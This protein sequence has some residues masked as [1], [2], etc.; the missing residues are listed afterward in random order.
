[1][2][3]DARVLAHPILEDLREPDT[4]ILYDGKRIPAVT[5]EPIAAALL[6]QGSG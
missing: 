6:L 3:E 2:E 4:Y 1:M 5:G